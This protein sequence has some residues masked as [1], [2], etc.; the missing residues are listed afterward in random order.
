MW[1]REHSE[2]G[3]K[4]WEQRGQGLDLWWH[5]LDIFISFSFFPSAKWDDNGVSFTGGLNVMMLSTWPCALD[6]GCSVH[7]SMFVVIINYQ[8]FQRGQDNFFMPTLWMRRLRLRGQMA[9][10]W[11]SCV[12]PDP[13]GTFLGRHT[14]LMKKTRSL[15]KRQ[16]VSKH[17]KSSTSSGVQKAAVAKLQILSGSKLWHWTSHFTSLSL[18]CVTYKMETGIKPTSR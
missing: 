18:S 1:E 15:D 14:R 16:R 4:E 7:T 3:V 5:I 10:E 11:Q 17:G 2:G 6:R 8:L 13:L 9:G 12:S